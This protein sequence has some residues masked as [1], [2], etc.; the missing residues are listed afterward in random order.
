MV[1]SDWEK[2]I[3]DVQLSR[4]AFGID[5]QIWLSGTRMISASSFRE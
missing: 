2:T 4:I 1:L 5:S 3:E